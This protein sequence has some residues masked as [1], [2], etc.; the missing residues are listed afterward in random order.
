MTLAN[1]ILFGSTTEVAHLLARGADVDGLDEYGFTPLIEAILVNKL[2][3]VRLLIEHGANVNAHDPRGRSPLHWAVENNNPAIC[4][5]LLEQGADPNAYTNAS[6]PVLMQ[7]LLRGQKILKELLY[8]HG[9]NLNFA[10]DFINTKLLGHRFELHGVVDIVNA[11]GQFIELDYEGFFLEFTLNVIC[12]SLQRYKNHFIAKHWQPLHSNLQQIIQAYINA[13]ELIKYQHFTVNIAE[14][15]S[16]I[17]QKLSSELLL[18]PLGYEGHAISFVKYGKW[19]ARCDRAQQ[20]LNQNVVIYQINHQD[21]FNTAFLKNLLYKKQSKE[22]IEQHLANILGLSPVTSLPLGSQKMGNCSWA[23][24]EAALVAMLFMLQFKTKLKTG[25]LDIGS[26]KQLSMNFYQQ[27]KNWDEATALHE[28]ISSFQSA[29]PAR[30]ASKAALLGAILFQTCK[31]D[32]PNG[33]KRAEKI[34]PILRTKGYEYVL[35]TYLKIYYEQERTLE[36]KNLAHLIELS[37]R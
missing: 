13:A 3:L 21:Q 29:S 18:L 10:Q 19:L 11:K 27:W 14:H 32:D 1:R 22:F 8:Q 30:K 20:D 37:G 33:L 15:E 5:V 36:G 12:H 7:P 28:C 34:I 26:S 25:T 35:A 17:Q 9:A 24:T 31:H 6:Q 4:K 23:N 2:D 16:I